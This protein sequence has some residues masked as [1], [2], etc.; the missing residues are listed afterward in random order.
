[1]LVIA[2]ASVLPDADRPKSWIGHQLGSFSEYLKPRFGH[3]SFLHGFLAL[4]LVTAVLGRRCG[5]SRA[6]LC[7]W[8]PSSRLRLAPPRRH[9]DARWS[10]TILAQPSHRR[11]PGSGRVPGVWGSAPRGCSSRA[12][13][14][15]LLFYPV[16]RGGFDGRSTAWGARMR[17]T[18]GS[19]GHRR[20]TV[21]V[22]VYGQIQP[23]RFIGLIPQR[24]SHG[25][26]RGLLR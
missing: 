11:L 2:A 21:S 15:S 14:L 17:S 8:W 26:T 3:R 20:D 6:V 9:D 13:V 25:P 12:F 7:S 22:E 18:P 24:P 10:P 1:M 16:S 19:P 5:G 4:L 23:V